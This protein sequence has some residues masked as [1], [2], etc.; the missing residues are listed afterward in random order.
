MLGQRYID[1]YSQ[2]AKSDNTLIVE[3]EPI[4]V[5]KKVEHSLGIFQK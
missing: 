1:A 5:E 3:G 4:D 2:L